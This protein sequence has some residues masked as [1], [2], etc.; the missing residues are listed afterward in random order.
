M[1]GKEEELVWLVEA[2][3]KNV[4]CKILK[5][6]LAVTD[7]VAYTLIYHQ[8]TVLKGSKFESKQSVDL[9][10]VHFCLWRAADFV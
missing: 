9:Q 4:M 6:H 3:V 2:F 7:F 5:A 8:K 10:E 1:C